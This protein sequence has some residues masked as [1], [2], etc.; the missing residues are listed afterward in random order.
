MILDN[1][2][3]VPQVLAVWLQIQMHASVTELLVAC[4]LIAC[5]LWLSALISGSEVAYFSLGRNE[6][7]ELEASEDKVDA[8]VLK[9][10]NKPKDLLAGLLIANN[11]VNVSIV[12][13]SYYITF[14]GFSF[15]ELA[16]LG[17][18]I[19]TVVVTFFIVMF[20]EVVPK[21]YAT[22]NNLRIARKLQPYIAGLLWISAP[23]VKILV[24]GTQVIDSRIKQ[25]SQQ[26]SKDELNQAI[27]MTYEEEPAYPDEKDILKG[28]VNFGEITTKQIMVPRQEIKAVSVET[29]FE[30]L[31]V[32]VTEWGYSRVPV[33]RESLDQVEGIL[34]LK[35]LLRHSGESVDFDWSVL[36]RKPFFVPEKKKIDDLFRDFQKKHTHIA[37]VVDEYGGCSGLITLEDVLEEIVGEINDEYDEVEES[38]I[39]QIA[40]GVYLCEARVLLHDLSRQT[41]LDL[42]LFE[43][44][45]SDADTLAGLV[46]EIA[47]KFPEI[48]EEIQHANY[49]FFVTDADDRRIKTIRLEVPNESPGDG[50]QETSQDV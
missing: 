12:I 9:L 39:K 13:I 14:R 25:Q 46:L 44:Y 34:Y 43:D 31:L 49:R 11:T 17:Y 37:V 24:L 6:L 7:E 45:L 8:A 5:L 2:D 30:N 40:E 10:I 32:M 48:G 47:G 18:L 33:F 35:D 41:G 26:V 23:F 4:A 22:E 15:G 27:E 38:Q 20:G 3:E 16:W 28:I 50:M 29:T 19:Q 1:P 42:E 36:L 21:V